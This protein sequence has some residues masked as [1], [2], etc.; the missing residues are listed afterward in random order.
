MAYYGAPKEGQEPKHYRVYDY[1]YYNILNFFLL[2][3]VIAIL[4]G[5]RTI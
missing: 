1:N 3:A 4:F 5:L 2:L